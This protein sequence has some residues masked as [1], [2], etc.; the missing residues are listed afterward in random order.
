[1][2]L[3]RAAYARS[4]DM[5]HTETARGI[6]AEVLDAAARVLA[7]T[8]PPH[9][10][11]PWREQG[12][13]LP[14]ETQ[15]A[16]LGPVAYTPAIIRFFDAC[17]EKDDDG[18]RQFD[19]GLTA[20]LQG[21]IH[22]GML[23]G[24]EGQAVTIRDQEDEHLAST[25]MTEARI[26]APHPA[27]PP[28]SLVASQAAIPAD[29]DDEPLTEWV[30]RR[31]EAREVLASRETIAEHTCPVPGCNAPLRQFHGYAA[32]LRSHSERELEAIP[33]SW[34]SPPNTFRRCATCHEVFHT[35][36]REVRHCTTHRQHRPAAVRQLEATLS[37]P[38]PVVAE[39]QDLTAW[40]PP[41]PYRTVAATRVP[42]MGTIPESSRFA[43]AAALAW[44]MAI[45]NLAMRA[46]CVFA[47][48]K[49]VLANGKCKRGGA[50]ARAIDVTRRAQ[51]F[52]TGAFGQLWIEA[53]TNAPERRSRNNRRFPVDD[54]FVSLYTIATDVSPEDI[55][56]ETA[57]EAAKLAS[58]GLYSRAM[59]VLSCAARA[60]ESDETMEA[61]RQL[62]P[63][64]AWTQSNWPGL[65]Q[66]PSSVAVAKA[67]R[68]FPRGSASGPSGLAPQ[69]LS[70]LLAVPGS[71]IGDLLP[72]LLEYIASPNLSAEGREVWF[73][74]RLTPLE[75]KTGGVRP[76]AS[77][78]TLRRVLAK[79][80]LQEA[81]KKLASAFLQAGQ[82]AIGVSGGCEAVLHAA[83]RFAELA[84]HSDLVTWRVD[85]ENAFN[86]VDRKTL[87]DA[88]QE[89][90][91]EL[92]QYVSAAYGAPTL[93]FVWGDN[94]ISSQ[95][96]TQQGDPLAPLL[97]A[98][99]LRKFWLRHRPEGL[100]LDAWYA[101]DG[102]ISGRPETVQLAIERLIEHGPAFGLHVN[103]EKCELITST[104]EAPVII[105]AFG[106]CLS[107]SEW[108]HLG[109]ECGS[110]E[111]RARSAQATAEKIARRVRLCGSIASEDA[112]AC[113]SLLRLCG[114]FPRAVYF[115]RGLGAQPA[116]KTIDDATE[117]VVRILVPH[118]THATV[119]QVRQPIRVGGL[120][121]RSCER[122]AT[123]AFVAAAHTA[124]TLAHH[125]SAPVHATADPLIRTSLEAESLAHFPRTKALMAEALTQGPAPK[126]LQSLWSQALDA[127]VFD[128]LK[129]DFTATDAARWAAAAGRG[130][131]FWL[132]VPAGC[133]RAVRL[134]SAAFIV[135]VTRRLG[136]PIAEHTICPLCNNREADADG[137][138][139]L[140]CSTSGSKTLVHHAV[141]DELY[142]LASVGLL[143]PQKEV[144]A[145][146]N[147]PNQRMDI[148][149]PSGPE[150]K[151][152]LID[153]AVTHA[154]R[155]SW[156]ANPGH[157][158]R[159]YEPVKF[160]EYQP[161]V[162][163]L[164]Q[165]FVPMVFD[166]FGNMGPAADKTARWM[167][168]AYA[169]RIGN[170]RLSSVQFFARLN[171]AL[172]RA[173][174]VPLLGLRSS[175]V[176]LA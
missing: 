32:H 120:G 77:G 24:G 33:A 7:P 51:L 28:P 122:H 73:G 139:T 94:T 23:S 131:S 163:T 152:V 27:P 173:L 43:V 158:A 30:A 69:H 117:E 174:A 112:Q 105:S 75:K 16:L 129:E 13:Y 89:E 130:S 138:H 47:F 45:P 35:T 132:S 155:D 93:L 44:A 36:R 57:Q 136:L 38:A 46:W 85:L 114:G 106:K 2:P 143:R 12:R 41:I 74:A 172:F 52:T 109:V 31:R 5:P 97:F 115:M 95:Q 100:S 81:S 50:K 39:V 91:P 61:L 63:A 84:R 58:A 167:A 150:S 56:E 17:E 6:P 26:D 96:G 154:L 157:A 54:D 128:K 108:T 102:I 80:L 86:R 107:Y 37:A 64:S 59:A 18:R 135:H 3:I 82:A 53:T 29:F 87:W 88:V 68:S 90:A 168:R 137:N 121:Q 9:G 164:T 146:V 25:I 169:S 22:S 19:A 48:A 67:I 113:F 156:L 65:A 55:D 161:K 49:M 40:T 145:L 149:L 42:V 76:V 111:A 101:D 171:G 126:K 124:A 170:A 70:E 14:A 125:F 133:E 144:H 148:V 175:S 83:R 118:L 21:H 147:A 119:E 141:R 79:I 166:S 151:Q 142:T 72:A 92:L 1:M 34:W 123:V 104:G 10:S 176:R 66:R 103:V 11:L 60:P 78:E 71:T 127:E 4:L 162:N 99:V 160:A 62:H 165:E 20:A 140:C 134:S 116:W 110:A 8:L 98:L 153:V 159:C 15:E